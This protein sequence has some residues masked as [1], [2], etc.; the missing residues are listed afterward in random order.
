MHTI[1]GGW[2]EQKFPLCVGHEIVGVALRVG[3]KVTLVK[4]GQ[5]VG[6]GAQS[7]SCREF[8]TV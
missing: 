3:E 7:Y 2:G 6:V 4:V 5:R 8:L 1:T